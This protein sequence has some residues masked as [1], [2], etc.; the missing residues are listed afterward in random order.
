MRL[1]LTGALVLKEAI[2][3]CPDGR[4]I[5]SNTR[6]RHPGGSESMDRRES[7]PGLTLAI[8]L[9]EPDPAEFLSALEYLAVPP[10]TSLVPLNKRPELVRLVVGLRG[11]YKQVTAEGF[12]DFSHR[13]TDRVTCLPCRPGAVASGLSRLCA[14]FG[15]RWPFSQEGSSQPARCGAKPGSAV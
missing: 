11:L 2:L 5:S 4:G 8:A 3:S 7:R 10:G 13:P 12:P 9:K 15:M 6:Y 14:I 1:K